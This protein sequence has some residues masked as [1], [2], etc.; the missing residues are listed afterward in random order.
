MPLI[1]QRGLRPELLLLQ[2]AELTVSDPRRISARHAVAEIAAVVINAAGDVVSIRLSVTR[3]ICLC[4]YEAGIV[5]S[6]RDAEAVAPGAVDPEA[7]M[8]LSRT[9]QRVVSIKHVRRNAHGLFPIEPPAA[10]YGG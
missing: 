6:T 2:A 1:I 3:R 10:V 4:D 5:I 7:L 9:P 8:I